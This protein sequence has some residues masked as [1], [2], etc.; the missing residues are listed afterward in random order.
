MGKLR[1]CGSDHKPG[2]W[3]GDCYAIVRGRLMSESWRLARKR[4]NAKRGRRRMYVSKGDDGKDGSRPVDCAGMQLF[5]SERPA[6]YEYMTLSK[7]PDGSQ[8]ETSTL[9]VLCEMGRFKL[10]LSDRDRGRSLWTTAESI[11]E[12]LASLDEDL[13]LGTADWRRSSGAGRG[14]KK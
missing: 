13:Q 14:G 10:C 7:Y 4:L 8:R 3:C 9:L 5:A 2:E 12:G 6:L 11:E 1:L